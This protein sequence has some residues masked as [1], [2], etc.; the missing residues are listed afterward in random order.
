MQ[1]FETAIEPS[2]A[3]ETMET[4]EVDRPRTGATSVEL[5]APNARASA[6]RLRLGAPA[7]AAPGQAAYEQTCAQIM[8]PLPP[9]A[10]SDI[11]HARH[12]SEFFLASIPSPHG[13]LGSVTLPS[14]QKPRILYKVASERTSVTA[15][16][17]YA[18][19]TLN[20]LG[21]LRNGND[22]GFFMRLEDAE[23]LHYWMEREHDD[24]TPK[25]A[26][27]DALNGNGPKFECLRPPARAASV[28]VCIPGRCAAYVAA[29]LDAL[30][31][32]AREPN[33][34]NGSTPPHARHHRR[35][36]FDTRFTVLFGAHAFQYMQARLGSVPAAES[37]VKSA[38]AG[39]D[40]DPNE[41]GRA[42][43]HLRLEN[44]EYDDA[45]VLDPLLFVSTLG[46]SSTR[47]TE[48]R[49]VRPPRQ[50]EGGRDEWVS[51]LLGHIRE[52]LATAMRKTCPSLRVLSEYPV[53]TDAMLNRAFALGIR[54]TAHDFFALFRA[55]PVVQT[56]PSE[57]AAHR[58]TR[59]QYSKTQNE[60][61]VRC[62]PR[63]LGNEPQY[64]PAAGPNAVA[65]QLVDARAA[66]GVLLCKLEQH[67]PTMDF[68]AR[69]RSEQVGDTTQPP[70]SPF[71]LRAPAAERPDEA[72]LG[73]HVA[74]VETDVVAVDH[75]LSQYGMCGCPGQP[76]VDRHCVPISTQARIARSKLPHAK[77]IDSTDGPGRLAPAF[78]A[79][80]IRRIRHVVV[81][82]NDDTVHKRAFVLPC[83]RNAL[84]PVHGGTKAT[85][86]IFQ[87][88]ALAITCNAQ[89]FTY[90]DS[91]SADGTTPSVQTPR[92][93]AD[94]LEI[95]AGPR[96][97]LHAFNA[98]LKSMICRLNASVGAV[99]SR[100]PFSDISQ[101][102]EADESV[103]DRSVV[104]ELLQTT[105][106]RRVEETCAILGV[107]SNDHWRVGDAYNALSKQ[108][109]P[110]GLSQLLL[111]LS[112][113]GDPTRSVDAAFADA[114]AAVQAA[115]KK[116]RRPADDE[117]KPERS[118]RP[119]SLLRLDD[120]GLTQ[121]LASV[122]L[123]VL[124]NEVEVSTLPSPE[125]VRDVFVLAC[126]LGSLPPNPTT[127]EKRRL[128]I[129]KAFEGGDDSDAYRRASAEVQERGHR[130]DAWTS[131][132]RETDPKR[133]RSGGMPSLLGSAIRQLQ[134]AN[135]WHA[136]LNGVPVFVLER[137]AEDANDVHIF[138]VGCADHKDAKNEIA[139]VDVAAF[140]TRMHGT[141]SEA[142]TGPT[143]PPVA[144]CRIGRG[145][146]PSVF[147]LLKA[148]AADGS[149]RHR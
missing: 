104:D 81:P 136:D 41:A 60:L 128:T 140:L 61:F 31:F 45:R 71:G 12:E 127:G 79:V 118:E 143:P 6:A 34:E 125:T 56:A 87:E 53:L 83:H 43:I 101:L 82:L 99:E 69:V 68:L 57:D 23:L 149:A 70:S 102:D 121:L 108:L 133:M 96:G 52:A 14:N 10:H 13:M 85:Q 78:G 59:V 135:K 39:T 94:E 5:K 26:H 77:C 120:R 1:P 62:V 105:R 134:A 75:L 38:K 91:E 47:R 48:V 36:A 84:V 112:A 74:W 25:E 92:C 147:Q 28:V 145:A 111:D 93:E 11:A 67:G 119:S 54:A 7:I 55:P 106:R 72:G 50:D 148:D 19:E 2:S 139:E 117:P 64:H 122:G 124:E 138:A 109:G 115:S 65:R 44:V 33:A 107:N 89:L 95:E 8:Q 21:F 42:A 141:Q 27:V 3:A 49:A 114:A 58:L 63:A 130:G 76:L 126:K 129:A 17:Q 97:P 88:L 35:A 123:Q 90:T 37:Y 51:T 110:S 80:L 73:L 116:R 16:R 132:A 22:I 40:V 9:L 146:Q 24:C 18:H 66:S 46:G 100:L 98:Q 4:S 20:S 30:Q 137:G 113:T 32:I 142:K 29:M 103:D 15:R 131:I 86:A 144:L